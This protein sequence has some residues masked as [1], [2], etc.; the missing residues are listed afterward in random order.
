MSDVEDL[1]RTMMRATTIL[2]RADV[3]FVLGGGLAVYARGGGGSQHDVDFLIRESD[4]DRILAAFEAGGM[5]TERP[6]ADWL[7]KAYDPHGID[8]EV[9]ID[10][11]FRPVDRAV[12]DATLADSDEL[13]VGAARV[14][15]LSA[16][17]L[18][19]HG[20]LT[21]TDHECDLTAALTLTRAIREQIDFDRVRQ[22]TLT[23]PYARAFL[24]LVEEL[25]LLEKTRR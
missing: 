20:L 4:V 2:R 10:L 9:L 6:E 1:L 15:V 23:S 7:V 13:S 16:T 22:Q 5:R 21:L 19:V 25:E 8:G 14:S 17:E 12:T 18:L 3:P 24:T 11:I